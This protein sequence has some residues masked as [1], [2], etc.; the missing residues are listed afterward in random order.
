MTS[1]VQGFLTPFFHGVYCRAQP[2]RLYIILS[3]QYVLVKSSLKMELFSL[4]ESV[5]I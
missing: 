5:V 4:V 1:N 2:T 3:V